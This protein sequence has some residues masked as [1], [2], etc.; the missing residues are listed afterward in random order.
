MK[1]IL[2][3]SG[4][5]SGT[6]INQQLV[7][8]VAS[9][10]NLVD[11]EV[12]ELRN[13]DVPMFSEDTE[14]ANGIPHNANYIFEKIQEADGLIVSVNEHNSAPS[15]FFKNY[16]DWISR[17]NSKF[18]AGKNVLLMSTS[19]GERGGLSALEFVRD[20]YFLRFGAEI[21][22]SFSFPS[23]HKNFDNEK[24]SVKDEILAIGL[25]DLV[26]NFEQNFVD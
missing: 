6:S 23:F 21:T 14:K 20:H 4:S 15:A 10:I 17:I 9:K 13:F 2:A 25:D 12:I 8:F 5:N 22:E 18:L 16:F 26:S 3:F 7:H 24:N 11:V 19:P 1:K